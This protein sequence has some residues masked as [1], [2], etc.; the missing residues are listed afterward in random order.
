VENEDIMEPNIPAGI[1]RPVERS[2]T[3]TISVSQSN[4]V[5]EGSGEALRRPV[6]TIIPRPGHGES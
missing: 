6:A 1:G 5:F 4:Q 3:E 2:L